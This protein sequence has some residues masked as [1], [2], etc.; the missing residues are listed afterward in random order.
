M[1][2]NSLA[3]FKLGVVIRNTNNLAYE[4]KARHRGREKKKQKASS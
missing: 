2:A 3:S 1:S 4:F